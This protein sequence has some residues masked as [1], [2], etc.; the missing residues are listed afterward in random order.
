MLNNPE[1]GIVHL[2]KLL[3][4]VVVGRRGKEPDMTSVGGRIATA[5][6]A[7]GLTMEALAKK[8]GVTKSAI[9]QWEHGKIDNISADNLLKLAAALEVSPRWLWLWK[10]E[11]GRPI[12][13]GKEFH[14]D[15][16]ESDLVETF[17]VL[18]P[19]FR[20]ELLGDA[21]KYLRL[22]AKQQQPSRANPY[23]T[24]PKPKKPVR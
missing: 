8:I 16:D 23:P 6:Q 2:P 20:D 9:S 18:E 7:R 1:R 17:K 10:D 13:M 14:L 19:D 22:S 15:P 5:R 12:P 4:G 3:G 11:K 21:H 24:A